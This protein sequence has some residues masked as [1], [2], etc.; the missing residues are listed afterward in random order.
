MS[1]A[2]LAHNVPVA[3]LDPVQRRLVTG[4]RHWAVAHRRGRWPVAALRDNLWRGRAAAHLQLLIEEIGQAWP[5]PFCLAPPC[6]RQTSHDEATI[7]GMARAAADGDRPA[8]D[9][10]CAEMLGADARER[11]FRSLGQLAGVMAEMPATA[12]PEG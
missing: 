12:T 2:W 3:A 6:C 9:R 7:A 10:L 5:D 1:F 4:L 11:L 8:F